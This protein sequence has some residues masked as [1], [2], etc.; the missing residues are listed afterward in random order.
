MELA[1]TLRLTVY[2]LCAANGEFDPKKVQKYVQTG[3]WPGPLCLLFSY[4]ED[5]IAKERK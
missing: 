1:R 2:E 5:A 3:E 4:T